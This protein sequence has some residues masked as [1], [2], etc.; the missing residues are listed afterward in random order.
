MSKSVLGISLGDPDR[1]YNYTAELLGETIHIIRLGIGDDLKEYKR[2]LRVNDGKYDAFGLGG[3]DRFLVCD[4]RK[5]ALRETKQLLQNVKSTPVLDGSGL[6]NTLE[7]STIQYLQERGIVDFGHSNTMLVCAVDR[8]GMAE[9]I[10]EQGGPVIYGDLMFSMGI[11]IPIQTLSGLQA[12]AR[13]ALPLAVQM[14]IK[15]LYPTGDKQKSIVPKFEKQYA[16]ADVLCGDCHYIRRHM[17]RNL[18]G[19]TI[20]TNT[21]TAKDTELFRERG[22]EMLVTTTPKLGNR[23]PG[24]NVYEAAIVAAIGASA[25]LTAAEYENALA[26]IGWKPSICEL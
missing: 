19:K 9:A 5:Y 8:F 17:P 1:D 21:T 20:I 22:V 4:G 10:W 13:V 2:L 6:K 15:W 11:P 7:R 14:P 18:A 12:M 24:T 23:T 16:W 3:L 26:R 25:E